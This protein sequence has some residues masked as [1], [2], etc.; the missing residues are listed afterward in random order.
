M[1]PTVPLMP[2]LMPTNSLS[3]DLFEKTDAYA[4]DVDQDG[5]TSVIAIVG[6]DTDAA[7]YGLSSLEMMFS[8]FEGNQLKKVSIEDYAD[9]ELRGIYRRLLRRIQLRRPRDADSLF[10]AR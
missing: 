5:N 4:L 1:I 6:K 9:K 3:A 2:G 10:C 8:S 7:F